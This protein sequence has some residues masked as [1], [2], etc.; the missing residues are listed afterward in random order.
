MEK[1]Y[2]NVGDLDFKM[3]ELGLSL[4][5]RPHQ[6]SWWLPTR[7]EIETLHKVLEMAMDELD[8]RQRP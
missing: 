7:A 3:D 1:L 2:G 6:G 4:A 8:G 5:L